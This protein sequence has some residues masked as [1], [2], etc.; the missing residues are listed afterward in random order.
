MKD[1]HIEQNE[2]K[3]L[4]ILDKNKLIGTEAAEIQNS[5][6]DFIQK[7]IKRIGVDLAKVE[8]VTSWGIGILIHAFTTSTNRDV[9]FYLTG[10][11]DKVLNILKKVRLDSIFHIE[12]KV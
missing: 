11:N 9:Y 4:I 6:L 1:I 8:Y 2:D 7:G 3:A 5:V 10:V 12:E